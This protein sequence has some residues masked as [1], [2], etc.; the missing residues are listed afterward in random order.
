MWT[1]P[2]PSG[3]WADRLRGQD[4]LIVAGIGVFASL[5]D[6]GRDLDRAQGWPNVPGP[7]VVADPH[8]APGL[9]DLGGRLVM[10]TEPSDDAVPIRPHA[11]DRAPTDLF[12]PAV[13]GESSMR[14]R[15]AS[16]RACTTTPPHDPDS[17]RPGAFGRRP[18]DCAAIGARPRGRPRMAGTQRNPRAGALATDQLVGGALI[19]GEADWVAGQWLASSRARCPRRWVGRLEAH[20]AAEPIADG[21]IVTACD[22]GAGFVPEP[23]VAPDQPSPSLQ[24]AR[25][26]ITTSAH[27]TGSLPR[28]V[29]RR[30][31]PGAG[32][33][34]ESGRTAPEPD[35]VQIPEIAALT[36]APDKPQ[37]LTCQL[38]RVSGS[39]DACAKRS[40]PAQ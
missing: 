6:D 31:S 20:R 3:V 11:D 12:D 16:S 35:W 29:W 2:L 10:T 33:R 7:E 14:Q 8:S 37:S 24:G 23:V 15:R 17:G 21:A 26:R 27:Q 13:R 22:P 25:C 1:E 18:V 19:E 34:S 9:E 30:S 4:D 38:Y 32:A 36:T 40:A 5:S 28:L 39:P